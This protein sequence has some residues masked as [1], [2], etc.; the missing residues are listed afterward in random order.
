MEDAITILMALLFFSA[1]LPMLIG[2]IARIV[3]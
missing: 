2:H 3:Q 1:G